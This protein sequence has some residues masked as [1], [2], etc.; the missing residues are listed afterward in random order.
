MV[1]ESKLYFLGILREENKDKRR[2]MIEGEKLY[3]RV[4]ENLENWNDNL[5][6]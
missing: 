2:Y 1:W 5:I 4:L 6:E 3:L